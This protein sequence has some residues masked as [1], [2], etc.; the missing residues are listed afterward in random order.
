MNNFKICFIDFFCDLWLY[1]YLL[2]L[3]WRIIST[4]SGMTIKIKSVKNL[5]IFLFCSCFDVALWK[6]LYN[7]YVA[8]I[9]DD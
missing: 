8:Y 9:M 7:M 2:I 5:Q 3:L 4:P 1:V 6:M